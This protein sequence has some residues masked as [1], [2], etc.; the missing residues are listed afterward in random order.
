MSSNKLRT[1]KNH[2]KTF[3]SA[4]ELPET[5]KNKSASSGK[6]DSRLALVPNASTSFE[7]NND[8]QSE[9]PSR[10]PESA[11]KTNKGAPL[12]IYM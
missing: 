1:A 9:T 6:T 7:N 2:S 3:S 10:S 4:S 11:Q 5:N 12:N 8:L